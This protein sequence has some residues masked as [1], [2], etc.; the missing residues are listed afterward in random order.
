MGNIISIENG[1]ISGL[2]SGLG[3]GLESNSRQ[4]GKSPLKSVMRL[5]LAGSLAGTLVLGGCATSGS[6]S[7]AGFSGRVSDRAVGIDFDRIKDIDEIGPV[8]VI[9]RSR[10]NVTRTGEVYL[11]RGLAN[12]FSR[13]IDKMAR[14]LRES[15]VD[16]AN[17]SYTSW[18]PVADDI[19]ARAARK[20]VSY[21]V[22]IIGH[23]L[24]ANESSKFANYLEKN[25]V[26]VALVVAFD[27][28]ET[29]KVGPGSPEVI[30][31]YLPKQKT[32]NRILANE[33]FRG[34]ITNINV[35][36]DETITHTNVEKNPEFQAATISKVMALTSKLKS[37]K[38]TRSQND[39][40]VEAMQK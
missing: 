34:K 17:F 28:V 35:T 9:N 32:D 23:S 38:R 7:S 16:A 5:L 21:P 6:S 26:K 25:K 33:D 37:D 24:G 10:G 40:M 27:P 30:N 4:G 22:I 29:G 36:V 3:S 12:V 13:G 31:Y 19:I 15:G 39:I 18:K 8:D 11:M 14:D 20:E 2:G 1:V